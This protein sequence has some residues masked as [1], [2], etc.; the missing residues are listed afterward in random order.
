MGNRSFR[1]ASEGPARKKKIS[2]AIVAARLGVKATTIHKGLCLRGNYMGLVPV[3][4]PNGRLLFDE[5]SVLE[6]E[7]GV[8]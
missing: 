4:L 7:E 3:K 8:A 6:L 5:D 1:R 2:T